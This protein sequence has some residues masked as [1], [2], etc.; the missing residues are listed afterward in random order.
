MRNIPTTVSLSKL[1]WLLKSDLRFLKVPGGSQILQ[2]SDS[3]VLSGYKMSAE[4]FLTQEFGNETGWFY[5]LQSLG[6][7]ISM[8]VSHSMHC[9]TLKMII[10]IILPWLMGRWLSGQR[11]HC[12]SR[13][14]LI[15]ILRIHGRSTHGLTF[16]YPSAGEAVKTETSLAE[17]H[18]DPGSVR[19][20]FPRA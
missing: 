18:A 2:Q 4:W 14:D 10:I 15:Q 3:P 8:W 16:L 5:L 17:R 20:T 1:L 13:S 19:D 12:V 11:S 9:K 7:N 6:G